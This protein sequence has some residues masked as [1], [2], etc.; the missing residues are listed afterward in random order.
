MVGDWLD[1]I[2]E[3]LHRWG[4][5]IIK[6]LPNFLLA[7]LVL[8]VFIFIAKFIRK[9]VDRIVLRISKS[10][11][12]SGLTSAVF[13]TLVMVV[14]IMIALNILKLDKA[15]TSLLAGVGIIGLALGFA[16]QDLTANFISGT[17]IAFKRPF[18]VGHTVET[19]GFIGEVEDIQLRATKMKTF[20][21]LHVII[22]N[23][24]IFQK[25]IINYSL[26]KCRRVELEFLILNKQDPAT[27][28]VLV[29]EG[30]EKTGDNRLFYDVE[31]YFSQIEDPK[32]KMYISV[33]TRY[34]EP[35]VFFKAR[36]EAIVIIARVLKEN[37]VLT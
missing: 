13:Y 2:Q 6:M 24:D 36:H 27:I 32:I 11:S 5:F 30:L 4:L 8:F 20:A 10:E 31:V 1:L 22:P 29:K 26:T 34:V 37:G 17:F 12:I 18:E 3:K 21:G 7:L 28:A 25:P 19:N 9:I 35:N 14:G 15:V 33:W 23:K 16:F